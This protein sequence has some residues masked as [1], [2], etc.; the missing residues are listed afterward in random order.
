MMQGIKNTS[1]DTF[2]RL[3][4]N[5]LHY[6]VPKYQR[7]Y[8]WDKEQWS[9]LWYDLMQIIDEKD[10][11]YMG[12]LVLQTSDDKNYQIIDGQQ[13]LTTI[14]VLILAVVDSLLN[15]PGTDKEK[16][17]NKKRA[18][19]IRS[20]YIGNMDMLTLTSVNKLVLNRNNDHFYRTY[21][22]TLQEMPKR[23]LKASERLL[24][25]SF[26]TFKSYLEIKYRSAK[27][28][29]VF[30]ENLVNNIFFTVITV[31][32]ELNA[33]KVFE[34][35]NARGVQLSSSDLLK[36]YI[37]SVANTNDLH[38]TKLDEL[39]NIWAEIADI[40]K[41]SQ[42]SDYLRFYWNST[43]KTI[44]KN[45]LYKTIRN[46]IKTPEEA[47]SLLRDMRKKADIYIALRSPDD[48]LWRAQPEVSTNL[49]LL[50]LFN[51]IQPIPLLMSA[52]SNLSE[53][54][55]SSLLTK[56]VIISFRY[57]VICGKNPN[58]LENVYNKV[59]LDINKTKSYK[60]EDLKAGIY[61]T[62]AEFE[63]TFAYKE[64]VYSSRNNQ[65]AKYIL[66][67]IEKFE[68]G[69]SI[70]ISS[71]TLEHI[72]P[73]NP[74]EEW[75]WDDVKIQQFHYR[76]GNM[77]LLEAGKNRDLGNVS[78]SEKKAVYKKSTVPMTVE[79]GNSDLEEWTENCID[80]RQKKMANEAKGIWK[81]QE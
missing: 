59:A 48:E 35:L 74:N 76:L 5:G 49:G 37:F 68:S 23:G 30:I 1:N 34:T 25:S 16:E 70:D 29:V 11:H 4:G 55:F 67:K 69:A 31:T 62:D 79:I 46:E 38:Q 42:I 51:V 14:C 22:S 72:L 77:T 19:N 18:E 7:D 60:T 54:D 27:E 65:I 66:G 20:T 63:Q 13:R 21:L 80:T 41:D 12:Y 64:F 8:S 58:E 2:G 40:L 36:N 61:V 10:S 24:K 56:I 75:N 81:I 47:F 17:D 52:Y 53:R 6:E 9:D 32:D 57:N 44:R 15:L 26:E 3:M 45:Q 43:H 78:F 28:L 50:K 33:F 71:S 39:E 73:D